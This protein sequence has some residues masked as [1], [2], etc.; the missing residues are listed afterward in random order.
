MWEEM[1]RTLDFVQPDL[2]PVKQTFLSVAEFWRTRERANAGR[3][4]AVSPPYLQNKDDRL[5]TFPSLPAT[6]P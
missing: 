2:P 1:S 6:I 3:P 5:F 4:N